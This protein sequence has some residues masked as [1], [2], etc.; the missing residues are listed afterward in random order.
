[1]KQTVQLLQRM[2]F[3]QFKESKSGKSIIASNE[4]SDAGTIDR[5][6]A[7]IVVAHGT[8]AGDKL[9]SI[10]PNGN[11][12]LYGHQSGVQYQEVT[13]I[14]KKAGMP[15]KK[16]GVTSDFFRATKRLNA[17]TQRVYKLNK[18]S[19]SSACVLEIS[20]EAVTAGTEA[21]TEAEV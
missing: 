9:L 16:E 10:L 21:S 6:N 8:T 14:P 3:R 1:M 19:N 2:Q 7:S 18:Y 5:E 4:A 11:M 13:L 15:T 20:E 12:I 17:S